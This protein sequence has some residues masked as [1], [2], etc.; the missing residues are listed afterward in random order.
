M[1]TYSLAS[2]IVAGGA[3][4]VAYDPNGIRCS[5]KLDF[6]AM[7]AGTQ[8]LYNAN[9]VIVV[10]ASFSAGDIIEMIAMPEG[11]MVDFCEAFIHVV[12][13]PQAE[14]DIGITSTGADMFGEDL[15]MLAATGSL[16]DPNADA[17]PGGSDGAYIFTAGDTIDALMVT[18]GMVTCIVTLSFR[19][20]MIRGALTAP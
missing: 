4:G 9:G 14:L 3:G 1:T 2:A 16:I 12:N 20:Q 17:L 18:A 6:P 15:D 11:A 10:P 19:A 8:K 5:V 13:A 7:L